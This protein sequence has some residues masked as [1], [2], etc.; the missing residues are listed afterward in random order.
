MK[1]I[2]SLFLFLISCFYAHVFCQSDWVDNGQVQTLTFN[3]NQTDILVYGAQEGILYALDQPFSPN[4]VV[5]W[6]EISVTLE[7]F[8]LDSQ[9]SIF[10]YVRKEGM[11]NNVDYDFKYIGS[12]KNP[13]NVQIRTFPFNRYYFWIFTQNNAGTACSVQGGHTIYLLS[14]RS[15]GTGETI[16]A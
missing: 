16:N 2:T 11:P 8:I 12:I 14:I 6:L 5:P 1:L 4:G 13:I 7:P 3:S 9:C 15:F 10:L